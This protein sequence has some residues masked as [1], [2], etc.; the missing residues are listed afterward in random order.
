MSGLLSILLVM[1]IWGSA[2]TVTKL[3]VKE[4]T[5]FLFAFLRNLIA[6]IV[7]LPFYLRQRKKNEQQPIPY[8]K[9][10]FMGLSG[11][12]F[13]Y[14][15]FNLSLVYTSAS[16]GAMIQ[17][18][19][20]VAVAVPA[21]LFLKEKLSRGTILGILLSVIGV[22][23]VGFIGDDGD[24]VN[25]VLGNILMILSVFAWAIYTVISKSIKGNDPLVITAL[26]TFF[27][28]AF[29][30]PTLAVELWD[31]QIP[32]ITPKACAAIIYLGV[33][34]SALSFLLYDKALKTLSAA[35]V[36]NF[37]NLDP[38]IGAVIAVLF[39]K[40]TITGLQIIGGILVL[41]GVWLSSKPF[42]STE[43]STR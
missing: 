2:Y 11:I 27:G 7:L 25:N 26:S 37:M 5:P 22:I 23:L 24:S 41:A 40:D 15:F 13:F 6:S 1:L 18:M 19:M 9:V 21:V 34:A 36:G 12:T 42:K 10:V 17:G 20:P 4:I 31:Q 30:I 32:S 3:A 29:L 43:R 16:T 8:K 28:T 33:F 35:Q 38:V 39:L 14:A